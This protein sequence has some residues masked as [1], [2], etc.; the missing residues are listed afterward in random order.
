MSPLD[1]IE[2]ATATGPLTLG[3]QAPKSG[4]LREG[5]DADV[6]AFDANPIEDISVWGDPGRVTHVWKAGKLVKG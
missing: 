4:Q 2:A 3:P 5:Y 1:A 6:I